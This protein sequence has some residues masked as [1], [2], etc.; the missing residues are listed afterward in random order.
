MHCC[1]HLM[2]FK[3]IQLRRAI[4]VLGPNKEKGGGKLHRSSIRASDPAA[5]G[6]N[7]SAPDFLTIEIF[8]VAPRNAA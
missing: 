4:D 5:T 6:S 1:I 3:A 2:T 8:S 7:L